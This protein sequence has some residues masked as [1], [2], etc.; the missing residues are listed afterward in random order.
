MTV[1][2][3]GLDTAIERLIRPRRRQNH[4]DAVIFRFLW[5]CCYDTRPWTLI[6]SHGPLSS[7]LPNTL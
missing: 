2:N 4:D 1:G 3:E 7:R 5:A 6:A